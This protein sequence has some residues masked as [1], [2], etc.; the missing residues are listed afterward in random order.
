MADPAAAQQVA[1]NVPTAI[2]IVI[3]TLVGAVS[4]VVVTYI[5]KRG[6]KRTDEGNRLPD[7]MKIIQ[8]D[9]DAWKALALRQLEASEKST[10]EHFQE[11]ED[12]EDA[13]PKLKAKTKK[14]KT[15]DGF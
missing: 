15:L 8:E 9:R 4:T 3:T 12:T 13:P 1:Y 2:V 5:A 6:D 10:H 7:V 14:K 11:A